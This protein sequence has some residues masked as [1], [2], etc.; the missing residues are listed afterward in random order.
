MKQSEMKKS[1]RIMWKVFGFM[2]LPLFLLLGVL[3]LIQI[4]FLGMFYGNIKTDE[5]KNTTESVIENIENG[6]IQN[7]IL[8]LSSN[9]DIN[10][11]VIDTSVFESV[12][13]SG[14][15]FDSV[16]YGW[17]P[18]GMWNLYD[19]VQQNGG[20]YVRYYSEE[21]E[22]KPL[23]ENNTPPEFFRGD[24]EEFREHFQ[25]VPRPGF[26]E[27]VGRHNDLLYAKLAYLSDG[28]EIM[29]VADTRMSPLD[30]TVKTLKIQLIWCSVI[31][32]FVSLVVSYFVAKSV[33]RPIEVLNM[34]A[35]KLARGD[36]EQ[37]FDAK[38]YREIEELNDTL[39]FTSSELKK[40]ETLR[41]ELVANVSH[42]MRTPLTMIVG[43]GEAMR[44]IPGENNAENAQLIVDE[45]NRLTRFVNGVLDLSKLQS[46]MYEL[47]N[48]QTDLSEMLINEVDRYTNHLSGIGVT[49]TADI[50]ENISVLCDREKILQVVRNLIDNA[51]NYANDPKCVTIK[52]LAKDKN[53][54]RVE[55]VDNGDGIDAEELGYIWDRYYKTNKNHKRNVAGSGIGLSIVKQIL[56]LHKAK[57]GV[58]TK[59]GVGSCFWFELNICE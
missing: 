36:F 29:V 4:V 5:L 12:Y 56:L 8:F 52:L 21:K 27:N 55:I 6:D 39:N 44:D 24:R 45:A 7:R 3:W 37:K 25:R 41:R 58:E 59:K 43:Y 33:S 16:T 22:A 47:D 50:K 46:G 40:V 35:K 2:L 49:I 53:V 23:F 1:A 17:G 18:Y 15:V 28:S 14:E 48:E 51:V 11:H 9:G 38:G 32:V 20:E 30:S 10:I 34:S 54:V 31:T 42:D 57:F 13:T 26:F 19:E